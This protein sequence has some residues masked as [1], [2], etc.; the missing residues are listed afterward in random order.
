MPEMTENAA[1]ADAALAAMLALGADLDPSVPE[2]EF[3]DRALDLV[4]DLCHLGDRH[5][6][7]FGAKIHQAL[8][9]HFL[10]SSPDLEDYGGPP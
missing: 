6:V 7:D 2:G 9:N 5:G 8:D 1:R 10:E 3:W 4:A